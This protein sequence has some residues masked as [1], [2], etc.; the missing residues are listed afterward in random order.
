MSASPPDQQVLISYL[1]GTLPENDSE[2]I[3]ERSVAD[4]ELAGRLAEAE[5]DLVDSYVRGELS[6]EELE[7]FEAHYLSTERR[8]RK[9]AFADA[10]RHR[11]EEGAAVLPARETPAAIRSV[12]RLVPAWALAAAALI[13]LVPAGYLFVVNGTLR[14]ELSDTRA[15]QAS[16]ETR[17]ESSRKQIEEMRSAE[18]EVKKAPAGIAPAMIE[19]LK[20]VSLLLQPQTRGLGRV[21][22]L[23]V[24][25]GTDLLALQLQLES[26]EF[27]QYEVVLKPAAAERVLWRSGKLDPVSR[28]R[29]K[30]VTASVPAA[31]LAPGH[32]SAELVGFAPR[33]PSE[34]LASYAFEVVVR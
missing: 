28:G 5:N 29:Q 13:L 3:D 12:P 6:A 32:Y 25:P 22:T 9:V 10:L 26:D 33:K 24:P 34:S 14:R 17:A 15:R 18:A 2:R 7:R 21:E 19:R 8:R 1:L 16:L 30:S 4:D 23:A 31:L 11:I 20:I 27:P